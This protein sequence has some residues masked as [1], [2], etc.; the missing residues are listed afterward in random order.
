MSCVG[1]HCQ[2]PD[3]PEKTNFCH[4]R[5]SHL[6]SQGKLTSLNSLGS[7]KTPL[8][9]GLYLKGLQVSFLAWFNPG[10]EH[11]QT[12]WLI[13]WLT[14]NWW[15]FY[16]VCKCTVLAPFSLICW[17]WFV[18]F[19]GR[20]GFQVQHLRVIIVNL[21]NVKVSHLSFAAGRKKYRKIPK[22]SPSKHKPPKIV[23]Q[24]TLR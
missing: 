16:L 7:F 19:L 13:N 20:R 14:N 12:D 6:F 2:F 23:T 3:H 21:G 8:S 17:Q 4:L 9:L 22:I 24:K 10:P 5:C 11:F 18:P 15:L 1:Q